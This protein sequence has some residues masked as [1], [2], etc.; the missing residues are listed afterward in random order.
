VAGGA[1]T[2]D[3]GRIGTVI[4]FFCFGIVD[5]GVSEGRACGFDERGA[6]ASRVAQLVTMRC[7]CVFIYVEGVRFGLARQCVEHDGTWTLIHCTIINAEL[8]CCRN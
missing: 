2:H 1:R 4:M 3:I 6:V 5:D 7:G 8:P